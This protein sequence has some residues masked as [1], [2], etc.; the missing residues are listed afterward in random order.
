MPEGWTPSA[1]QAKELNAK[2][3]N[4]PQMVKTPVFW[5]MVVMFIF[6]N[7]CRYHDG[8]RHFAHCPEPDRPERHDCRHVCFLMTLANMCGRIGFGFYL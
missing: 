5:V 4:I 2:N 7:A 6:A 3:Y 1:T 8:Q